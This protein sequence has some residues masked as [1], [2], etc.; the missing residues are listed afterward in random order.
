MTTV[1][2]TMYCV[3]QASA[4]ESQL[5]YWSIDNSQSGGRIAI[6]NRS[7]KSFTIYEV[8][9]PIEKNIYYI[10]EKGEQPYYSNYIEFFTN[11]GDECLIVK[12]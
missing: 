11:P 9:C 10:F 4:V 6:C 2:P 7:E 8:K 3:A 1:V 12:L 5:I